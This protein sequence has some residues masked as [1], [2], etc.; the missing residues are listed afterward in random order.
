MIEGQPKIERKPEEL[1]N[2][3]EQIV[4]KYLNLESK[5]HIRRIVEFVI[6]YI[7]RNEI[8]ALDENNKE[9][10]KEALLN[11]IGEGG[12]QINDGDLE[13]FIKGLKDYLGGSK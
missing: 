3:I 12:I 11:E 8:K 5:D 13:N 2:Q 10:F 1:E 6:E 4:K 9:K 7:N